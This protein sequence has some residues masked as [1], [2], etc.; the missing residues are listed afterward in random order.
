MIS[1]RRSPPSK[2]DSRWP[3]KVEDLADGSTPLG[4]ACWTREQSPKK[5]STSRSASPSPVGVKA[6]PLDKNFAT[7]PFFVSRHHKFAQAK[8]NLGPIHPQYHSH[9]RPQS[10][11]LQPDPRNAGEL[12]FT[13]SSPTVESLL[14]PP[15]FEPLK[16]HQS[17]ISQRM[18][19]TTS[20]TRLSRAS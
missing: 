7:A 11:T 19:P 20:K 9:H 5:T 2:N 6:P 13:N 4:R 18:S 1:Q 3:L 12:H 8:T 10:S 17:M 16:T 15:L 14:P